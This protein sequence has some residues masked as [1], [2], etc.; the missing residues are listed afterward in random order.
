MKRH[1]LVVITVL[2]LAVPVM[3]AEKMRVAVIDLQ[4][5]GVSKM[6]SYAVSDLIRSEMVRTGMFIIVERTQMNEILKEQGLQM[7]GCT[8]SA[9]AVEMGKLLS[10]RK[11]LMGEI[12]QLGQSYVITVRIVD[13]EKG[14]SEFSANEKAANDDVLDQASKNITAKLTRNIVQGDPGAFVFTTPAGYYTRSIIPGWGQFYA[15]HPVKGTIFLTAFAGSLGFLGYSLYN[16]FDKKS[17]YEDQGPPQSLI[18]KKYNEYQKAA[19]LT[20]YAGITIGVVYLLNWVDVLF[21]SRP[22]FSAESEYTGLP[23]NKNEYICVAAGPVSGYQREIRY[24]VS[25]AMRF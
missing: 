15:G 7:S 10:A 21:F 4:G 9:C 1:L 20:L 23:V 19:D 8:D 14:V 12:N 22:D 25:Y 6:V 2:A 24:A 11:I 13:V 17:A 18:D 16:Y 5:K 3:G